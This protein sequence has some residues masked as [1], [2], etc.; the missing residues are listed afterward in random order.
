MYNSLRKGE[1]R[2]ISEFCLRRGR[3]ENKHRSGDRFENV[4]IFR[5]ISLAF[6]TLLVS[7]FQS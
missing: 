3:V 1:K 5:I 6:Q 2:G 4:L 7:D